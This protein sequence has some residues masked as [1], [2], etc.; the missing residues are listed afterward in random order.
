MQHKAA[1][2][3]VMAPTP[4]ASTTAG[5]LVREEAVK[6]VSILVDEKRLTGRRQKGK[7]WSEVGG[8]N[9]LP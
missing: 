3:H 2:H 5:L 7:G 9:I 8:N 1:S 4:F 6:T